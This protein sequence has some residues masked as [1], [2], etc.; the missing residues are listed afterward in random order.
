MGYWPHPTEN[1]HLVISGNCENCKSLILRGAERAAPAAL[2][3]NIS[4][5][6]IVSCLDCL[7]AL[8]KIND[9]QKRIYAN[10][11][12]QLDVATTP[13]RPAMPPSDRHGWPSSR[14]KRDKRHR[15]RRCLPSRLHPPREKTAP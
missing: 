9:L 7:I 2:V 12:F 14:R 3:F 15:L 13:T 4:I 10:G 11:G 5:E 1:F 8:N 6:S